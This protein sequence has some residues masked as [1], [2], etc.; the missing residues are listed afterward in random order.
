MLLRLAMALALALAV[1]FPHWAI[2][3]PGI[4]LEWAVDGGP[5]TAF[6]VYR[7]AVGGAQSDLHGGAPAEPGLQRYTFVDV[8][9]LPAQTYVCRVEAVGAEGQAAASRAITTDAWPALPAQLALLVA[10]L[11]VG[12]GA[13]MLLLRCQPA[14]RG[15][16][17]GMKTR[18][19]RAGCRGL[20]RSAASRGPPQDQGRTA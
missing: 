1:L 10:S 16:A 13:V 18:F 2:L 6:R 12:C 14:G 11:I 15:R 5:L 3:Q 4:Q 7:T 20:E 9:V 19:R 8:R 17:P